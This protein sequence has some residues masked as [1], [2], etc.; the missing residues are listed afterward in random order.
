MIVAW[1]RAP[2]RLRGRFASTSTSTKSRLREAEE[3]VNQSQ[4][5]HAA[6]IDRGL[7]KAGTD[8]PRLLEPSD[9]AL[10]Y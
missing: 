7:L 2:A 5:D 10:H 1:V 3:S 9:E 8:T 4:L 6:E